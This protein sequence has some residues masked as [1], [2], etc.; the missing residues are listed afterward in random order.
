[1]ELYMSAYIPR[2]FLYLLMLVLTSSVLQSRILE[3]NVMNILDVCGNGKARFFLSR[4]GTVVLDS[5]EGM[6]P[7]EL[8]TRIIQ[9]EM[10]NDG[11]YLLRDDGT[12]W[13]FKSGK[14]TIM[15]IDLPVRQIVVVGEELYFLTRIGGLA[16]FVNGKQV[17]LLF[18]EGYQIAEPFKSERLFL[19]DS[20]GRLFEYY[21]KSKLVVLRDKSPD[22]IQLVS[23][24]DRLFVLKSD[25]HVYR[26]ED[27]EYHPLNF[28]QKI[29]MIATSGNY[30]YVLSE[31]GTVWE[32]SLATE[33]IKKIKI[34]DSIREIYFSQNSLYMVTK[35]TGQVFEYKPLPQYHRIKRKN[36]KRWNADFF[37][38]RNGFSKSGFY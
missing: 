29:S 8:P 35:M 26:Y 30:L 18:N 21:L 34:D 4:A 27:K 37:P 36:R 31:D 12:V 11:L 10:S 16:K 22:T 38:D 23:S 19:V 20:W 24:K 6:K 17:D 25:G 7:L 32:V 3:K 1:M 28:E 13:K 9:I 15:S 14:M 5:S 2:S 33:D